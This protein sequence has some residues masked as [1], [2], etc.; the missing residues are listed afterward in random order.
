M[1]NSLCFDM[2]NYENTVAK[3]YHFS[4][5]FERYN[6][7]DSALISAPLGYNRFQFLAAYGCVKELKGKAIQIFKYLDESKHWLFGQINYEAKNDFSKNADSENIA[8][9]QP[10]IVVFIQNNQLHWVNN[11]IDEKLFH[12]LIAQFNQ[13]EISIL[14]DL[15]FNSK[16]EFQNIVS[17]EKYIL[18]V[19]KIKQDIIEGTYYEMNYCQKFEAKN[20]LKENDRLALINKLRLQSPA[21]FGAFVKTKNKQ[22]LCASPERFLMREGNKLISQPI[23]GTNKRLP[24]A[25]NEQQLQALKN[26]EKEMAENVMIV[27]LVRNDLAHV[28]STGTIKVEELCGTYAFSKVNQMISTV[29]GQLKENINFEAIITALFPMGSMTGAP[30]IE[31]MRNI[32]KYEATER[33]IYSGCIGYI[34]PNKYF[35][36]NVVIRTLVIEKNMLYYHTGGA[37]TYDSIAEKEYEECLLKGKSITDLFE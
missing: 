16:I 36:F 28:C 26:S 5:L 13:I 18:N 2:E 21:P 3:L 10:Q 35:D 30:K 8:F 22:I 24:N 17:K 19:E 33:G 20:V 27:D 7:Y 4:Q 32:E 23:K 15:N 25:E 14:N 12:S 29:T 1:S 9:Y 31:V 11:G 6:V 34:M 37:I